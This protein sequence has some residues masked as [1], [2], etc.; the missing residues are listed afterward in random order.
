[1]PRRWVFSHL[2]GYP[3]VHEVVA[4]QVVYVV[5]VDTA[6][7]LLHAGQIARKQ[8]TDG[9]QPLAGINSSYGSVMPEGHTAQQHVLYHLGHIIGDFVAPWPVTT[10]L[11]FQGS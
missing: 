4:K 10:G 3:P 2:F 5:L 6:P 11:L 9:L 7:D 8:T 1:M